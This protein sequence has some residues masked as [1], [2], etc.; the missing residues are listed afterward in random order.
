MFSHVNSSLSGITTIRSFEAQDLVSKEFDSHQDLHTRAHD[1]SIVSSN[2]FGFWIE[3]A[4]IGF[5]AFV[6][7]SFIIVDD[8]KIHLFVTK[9][10]LKN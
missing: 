6:T 8:G 7:Y 4:S 5:V 2:A 9:T 10:F 1:L 3:M